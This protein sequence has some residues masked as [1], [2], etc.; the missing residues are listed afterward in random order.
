MKYTLEDA[1]PN[2][3][4]K[5][6]VTVVQMLDFHEVRKWMSETYGYTE[7]LKKDQPNTNPYWAFTINWRLLKIYLR[8]DKELSWFKIRY[9]DPL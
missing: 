3:H 6:I 5:Y 2:V 8:G 1:I 7:D 4:F 9:G